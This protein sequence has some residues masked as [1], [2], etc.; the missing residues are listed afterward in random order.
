MYSIYCICRFNPPRRYAPGGLLV[1]A[2]VLAEQMTVPHAPEP[3]FR[4][5]WSIS[6][7]KFASKSGYSTCSYFVN[8]R[9]EIC[10][11]VRQRERLFVA[12]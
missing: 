1:E 5:C 3:W 12:L 4:H 2:G 8:N 9:L 11:V 10:F 7:R 6:V